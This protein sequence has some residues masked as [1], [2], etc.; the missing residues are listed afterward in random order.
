MHQLTNEI[1]DLYY[2]LV[3]SREEMLL[4]IELNQRIKNVE[5]DARFTTDYMVDIG[6]PIF[7]SCDWDYDGLRIYEIVK[8]KIPAIQLL[9]PN[10]AANGIIKSEHKSLWRDSAR[11]ELL[12]GLNANL[13]SVDQQVLIHRLITTNQWITEES[14][15]LISMVDLASKRS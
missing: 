9:Y 13:F 11:P 12:S 8:K 5:I 3:P 15:E 7:Y 10:G 1:A 4:L 2:Q 14:N 6:L